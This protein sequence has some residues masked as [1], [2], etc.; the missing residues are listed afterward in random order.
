MKMYMVVTS[1]KTSLKVVLSVYLYWVI[2]RTTARAPEPILTG[3]SKEQI[4]GD[5]GSNLGYFRQ[6]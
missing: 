3:L 5:V 2:S 1:S 4:A 6:T